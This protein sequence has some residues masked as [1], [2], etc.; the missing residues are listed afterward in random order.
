MFGAALVPLSQ[1]TMLDIYP[2]ERRASAMA[3]W[4]IGV[5]VGP[6]LGPTLGGYLTDVYNWRWVFYVNLPFGILAIAGLAGVHAESS[7]PT[8]PCASTGPASR[9]LALGIGSF[10]LMLDRGQDQDWF[11]SR[12]IITEAVLAGLGLY[13]FIVHMFTAEKPFL[14]PAH[15]PRPQLSPPAC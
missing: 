12:E 6:I 10:Q 7:R 13:L 5:M 4:G 8:R 14:P 9:V 1:A 2:I 3:I 15:L 11:S